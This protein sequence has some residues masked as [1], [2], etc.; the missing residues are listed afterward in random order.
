M[1]TLA[2]AAFYG[3]VK[4]TGIPLGISPVNMTNL[5]SGITSVC[6]I[7]GISYLPSSLVGYVKSKI[8]NFVLF[9]QFSG[10][11]YLVTILQGKYEYPLAECN[12]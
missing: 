6:F 12:Y 2:Y 10:A 7:S 3:V 5:I 4:L 1:G 11:S 9:F 8:I